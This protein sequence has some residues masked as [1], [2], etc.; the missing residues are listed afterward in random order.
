MIKYILPI[1]FLVLCLTVVSC[2]GKSSIENEAFLDYEKYD[3]SYEEG[4]KNLLDILD[5]EEDLIVSDGIIDSIKP[6]IIEFNRINQLSK[7]AEI[8]IIEFTTETGKGTTKLY[9]NEK[10]EVEKIIV[11]KYTEEQQSLDVYYLKDEQLVLK[12]NQS[13]MYN[14]DIDNE[15]FSKDKSDYIKECNYFLNGELMSIMNNQDCGAP[16]A[17][18]YLEEVEKEIKEEVKRLVS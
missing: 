16:F 4:D 13:L 5:K 7:W 2:K 6:V 8:S 10:Q 15:N 1:S 18:N 9:Y 12:V 17:Q 11:R 3:L 14:I